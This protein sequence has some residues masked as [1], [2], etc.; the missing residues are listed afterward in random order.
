MNYGEFKYPKTPHLPFSLKLSKKSDR[1]FDIKNIEKYF[2]NKEV[3]VTE[4][5]DG[6]NESLLTDACL[7]RAMDDN[8]FMYGHESRNWIKSFWNNIRNDIPEDLIISIENMF[9]QHTIHYNLLPSYAIG[10]GVWSKSKNCLLSYDECLEWFQL[11]GITSAPLLYR[12]IYNEDKIKEC[13]TGKSKL[14]SDSIQEGY[15][16]R[17]A[18]EI[19]RTQFKM[20]VAK[21][22]T[23]KFSITSEHWSKSQI[24][25]N[26]LKEN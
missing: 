12:G 5:V 7:P 22:V 2:L 14:A 19:P 1:N 21:F 24:I 3:I 23:T 17:L 10:L 26:K 15:V 11:L 8:S 25:L 13:F 9:A 4:K 20:K 6:G 16:V 18:E